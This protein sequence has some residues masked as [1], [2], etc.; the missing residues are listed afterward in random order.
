[1]KQELQHIDRVTLVRITG[2]V[3]AGLV[4]RSEPTAIARLHGEAPSVVPLRSTFGDP[5]FDVRFCVTGHEGVAR[6][7]LDEPT[8]AALCELH[9]AGNIL[10]DESVIQVWLPAAE[11]MARSALVRFV[12]QKTAPLHVSHAAI[13]RRL[14]A[15]ARATSARKEKAYW[16][17]LIASLPANPNE[18]ELVLLSELGALTARGSRDPQRDVARVLHPLAARIPE[19]PPPIRRRAATGLRRLIDAQAAFAEQAGAVLITCARAA[20]EPWLCAHLSRQAKHAWVVQALGRVGR[21]DAHAALAKLGRA[22]FVADETKTAIQHAMK[23]IEERIGGRGQLSL[24]A[25][26]GEVSLGED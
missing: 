5:A 18:A 23:A 25:D 22:F 16:N 7:V 20:D 10:V 6:A 15:F 24:A 19:M 21:R 3:P 12:R 14:R 11:L 13:V 1:M 8:R 9:G 26:A 17:A 4:L 2:Q